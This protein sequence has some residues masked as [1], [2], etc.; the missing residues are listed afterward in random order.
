MANGVEGEGGSVLDHL[1][2]LHDVLAGDGILHAFRADAADDARAE[3]DDFFVTVVNR[4][5]DDALRSAAVIADDDDV[6]RAIHELTREIAGVGRLER[7]VGETLAGAVRGDEVLEHREALA[8][9]RGDG[10]LDDRAVGLGHEAAH[11]AELVHLR[12]VTARAGV[13]H[14][15]HGVDFLAALIVHEGA[16][17]DVRDG[18]VCLRPRIDDLVVALAVGNDAAAVLLVDFRNRLERVVEG[19]LLL[20]GNDHVLDADGDAGAH[21]PLESEILE[22]IEGFDGGLLA[23]SVVRLGDEFG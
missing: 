4:A 14:E 5:D 15:I 20:I 2:L 8:E 16:E 19:L 11:A 13:H 22:L 3:R 23:G 6:L 1:I 7:G 9:V 17:H 12:A 10:R 18:V 21:R